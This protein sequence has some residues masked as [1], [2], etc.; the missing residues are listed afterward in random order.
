MFSQKAMQQ[1][2]FDGIASVHF[3]VCLGYMIFA[4]VFQGMKLEEKKSVTDLEL[5]CRVVRMLKL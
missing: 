3:P 1:K 5:L 4:C 2:M